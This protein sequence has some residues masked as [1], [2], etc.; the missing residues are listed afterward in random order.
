MALDNM[1]VQENVCAVLNIEEGRT[2]SHFV[3]ER[4]CRSF[5]PSVT[6]AQKV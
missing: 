6:F 3:T 5:L 2:E 4:T 1:P